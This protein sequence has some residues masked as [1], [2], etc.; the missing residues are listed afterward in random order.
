[1]RSVPLLA[2]REKYIIFVDSTSVIECMMKRSAATVTE[3]VIHSIWRQVRGPFYTFGCRQHKWEN[4]SHGAAGC[5]HCG[6]EHNCEDR[7]CNELVTSDDGVVACSVTGLTVT[8]ICWGT[9][10]VTTCQFSEPYAQIKQQKQMDAILCS[11]DMIHEWVSEF[12]C[13]DKAKLAHRNELEKVFNQIDLCIVRFVRRFKNRENTLFCIPDLITHILNSCKL[14][15]KGEDGRHL[16]EKCT[17]ILRQC[18]MTLRKNRASSNAIGKPF[19]IGLLY[20][21]RHGL[22]WENHIWLPQVT[23]LNRILPSECHLKRVFG[24]SPKSICETEN[25]VKSILRQ[26][27]GAF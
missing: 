17:S 4:Y 15:P 27:F 8:N 3:T 10:F 18:V 26:R 20:L 12:L 6:L 11:C 19:I 21:M 1:M 5:M 25:E 13:S 2:T 23:E 24:I 22:I 14:S 16:V 7:E 9:E